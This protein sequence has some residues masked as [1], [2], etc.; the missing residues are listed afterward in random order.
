MRKLLSFILCVLSLPLLVR[1]QPTFP[2]FRVA[3]K[4]LGGMWISSPI[5]AVGELS[6][7]TTYGEQAVV[8]LPSPMSPDTH[9]LYW[10]EGD[11]NAIAIVK[12][13]LPETAKKYL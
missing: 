13:A 3:N 11:F 2:E 1:A 12:G 4:V 6:N 10:C 9:R 5:V 7:V 8:N